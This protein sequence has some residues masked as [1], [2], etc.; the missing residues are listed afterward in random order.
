VAK[1]L[2]QLH[3]ASKERGKEVS[4]TLEQYMEAF[5]S[6]MRKLM[7]ELHKESGER[8]KGSKERKKD[9]SETLERYDDEH[10][11]QAQELR[12]TLSQY[13]KT[14]HNETNRL[15]G[16]YHKASQA[17]HKAW[18]EVASA[19]H[20]KRTGRA[21]PAKQQPGYSAREQKIRNLLQE[22]PTGMT[23]AEL[24]YGLDVPSSTV[25]KALHRMSEQGQI[26][27]DKGLYR[28]A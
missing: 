12:K 7:G 4:E 13:V 6:E 15:I 20:R 18:Q 21:V 5:G 3:R 9:V 2:G 19:M 8:H 17:A 28:L 11:E 26:K 23:L 27:K 1:L 22:N 14:V 10:E 24:A 25:S 16:E